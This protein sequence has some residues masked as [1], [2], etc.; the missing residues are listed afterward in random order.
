MM[1]VTE[2]ELESVLLQAL[3]QAEQK[4]ETKDLVL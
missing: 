3:E 4:T 2:K 1:I